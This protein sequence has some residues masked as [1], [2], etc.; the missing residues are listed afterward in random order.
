MAS[1]AI[2]I[3][4]RYLLSRRKEAFINII[5]I[6]S[7]LGVA[8]GVVVI[9]MTMAIMTGFEYELKK[10]IL[11]VDAH[12]TIRR[13]GGNIPDWEGAQKKILEVPDLKGVSPFTF[14]QGLLRND[15]ASTGVLI[16][17]VA[18]ESDTAKELSGY[19]DGIDSG[20]ALSTNTIQRATEYG[21]T[22]T[23][24]LPSI[25]IGKELSLGMGIYPGMTVS[26][27]SPQVG[28]TPL[29]LVPKFR[30]FYVSAV[31]KSGLVNYESSIAYVDLAEAQRFFR[32]GDQV[33]GFEIRVTEVDNA[34]ILAK[35][36]VE[37]FDPALGFYSQDW[38]TTNKPLWDA[39][40]L[41]KNVYFIV[42]LLI[43]VM[44][45][46]SII[47]TLVLLVLEKRGDIAVLR[48]I[49]ATSGTVGKIF[50][51]QGALIGGIGTVAGLVLGYL[52][53]IAL[54]EYG[55]PLDERIFPISEVPVRIE[56]LNFAIVGLASFFICLL[57]T[58]YPSRRASQL[59]PATVLRYE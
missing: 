41:E 27:L 32:L 52:G 57:S 19:L 33:S 7:I 2:K 25:V 43:I 44:A 42:L 9:N 1:V 29:G 30:R 59:D 40:K 39:I 5:T 16:R 24:I 13:A 10:K 36:I 55:F 26:V 4:K 14:N 11:E 51:I 49:G 54:K 47:S 3:A 28:S 21:T 31:Y 58:I 35:Q 53:C 48:T 17:G 37:K 6:I 8:I 18:P 34:P 50:R 20:D 38:T 45:S 46:F 23:T 56:L 15:S 22:E 12:V